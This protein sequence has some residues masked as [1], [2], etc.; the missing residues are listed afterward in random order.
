MPKVNLNTVT[1]F[2]NT[3]SIE[4]YSHL[5]A[6]VGDLEHWSSIDLESVNHYTSGT[7]EMSTKAALSRHLEQVKQELETQKEIKLMLRAALQ[8]CQDYSE[9]DLCVGKDGYTFNIDQVL[10]LLG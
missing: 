7:P 3:L 9:N 1:A 2:N 4:G 10:E 5:S 6:Y 8:Q